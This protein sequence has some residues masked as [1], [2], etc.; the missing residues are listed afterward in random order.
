LFTLGLRSEFPTVVR[1]C[2]SSVV[3]KTIRIEGN[4]DVPDGGMLVMV[5]PERGGPRIISSRWS[6]EDLERVLGYTDIK[7]ADE[8][9]IVVSPSAISA[10]RG[11]LAKMVI[12][13]PG[14]GLGGARLTTHIEGEPRT[15]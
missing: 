6:E 8:V 11:S 1:P 5:K 15:R 14:A 13:A 3:R 9:V 10:V 7:T 2:G 12:V 4:P